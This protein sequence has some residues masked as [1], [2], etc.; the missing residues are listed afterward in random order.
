MNTTPSTSSRQPVKFLKWGAATLFIVVLGLLAA[1][2]L[3]PLVG[4]RTLVII[5]GSMEP[6]IHMGAAAV[7]RSVP[8]SDLQVGDVIAYTPASAGAIPI[9]HRIVDI[10]ERAGQRTFTT[11]GDANATA[12][13]NTFTLPAKAWRVSY[14][15]PAAGYVVNFAS[16]PFGMFLF[17]VI[18][19]LIL[20][21]LKWAEWRKS[22]RALP[23]R[24]ARIR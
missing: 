14:N 16:R 20:A 3:P 12:D 15:I 19:A 18:P 2:A 4:G 7:L 5:S 21:G 23:S 22:R 24:S 10:T 9:V 8:S 13:V 17:I 11:K 6:A 1:V